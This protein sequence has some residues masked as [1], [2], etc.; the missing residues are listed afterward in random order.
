MSACLVGCNTAPAGLLAPPGKVKKA[1]K[2]A[3]KEATE[4]DRK[5][6][7]AQSMQVPIGTV[8]MIDKPGKF[9]L[10]KSNR[11]T[12]LEPDTEVKAYRQDSSVSASL[13]VSPARKGSYLTADL[14]EGMPSVGDI[15]MMVYSVNAK[16]GEK[17]D[18]TQSQSDVQVLE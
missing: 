16:P 3:D 8:H 1:I 5:L 17:A 4:D 11:T 14:I 6:P 13:K 18:G 2:K 10:I 12:V 9:V 7:L 15:V